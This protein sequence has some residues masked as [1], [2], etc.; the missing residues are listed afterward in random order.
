[1]L[2]TIYATSE[3]AWL[4]KDGANLVVEVD[5][6]ERGRV[7]LH[8]LEGVVSFGRPGGSPALMAACAE[9][10]VSISYLSP[11]GRFLARVEGPR[12]GNVLLRRTQYRLADDTAGKVSIV[13][14]MVTAKAANQ[15]TVV[16]RALRDH[17]Q[18][19]PAKAQSLL[20]AAERRMAD[21]ARRAAFSTDVDILRGLEGEAAASYFAVFDH[22][23]R[24]K[25]QSFRFAGRSR[26]PPLDRINAI[27][28][29]LY[30]MLGH[31]CRSA[32]E[33]HGLDPQ[34][35]FLHT[36][37]PG[38]ASLALDLM[39]ELRPVLADRLALTLVNRG[40]LQAGDFIVEETGGVRLTDEARKQVLIAWQ[41][42]K[43]DELRHP[44]LGETV[45]L[46]LVAHFQAQLLARHL[47]GDLD[48]YPGFIWK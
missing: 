13:R 47:R 40:Q 46:G 15:R 28:S 22:L 20:S 9:A 44:F 14:G 3:D 4:R 29:F 42:R 11:N 30:A 16:Q 21:V 34:V 19:L 33:T 18:S 6:A 7:P 17:G 2:N 1:M 39:E 26:R 36:D 43:R 8:M 25:D 24:A 37:R 45:P 31:D 27:L 35:G 5:G 23:I 41:E 48:G 38:R 10:G 32:L 12:S